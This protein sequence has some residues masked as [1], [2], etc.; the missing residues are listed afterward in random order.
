MKYKQVSK[1]KYGATLLRGT[2]R[3]RRLGCGRGDLR[4]DLLAMTSHDLT[5]DLVTDVTS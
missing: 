2:Y 1:G 3:W 5:N 4:V